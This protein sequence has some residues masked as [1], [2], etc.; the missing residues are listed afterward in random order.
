V[1][2]L[3]QRLQRAL[4]KVGQ[5][6]DDLRA[7]HLPESMPA[8]EAGFPRLGS[9][10]PNDFLKLARVV[11]VDVIPFPPV[12]EYG[13]P[14]FESLAKMSMAGITFRDM[15]FVRPSSSSEGI[16]FHELVH[17]VQWN[18]LGVRE[19]L[20][21]Y[22]LGIVQCGYVQSPLEAIAF[23]LQARFERGV[24]LPSVPER[25]ARHAAE[26]RDAASTVFQTYGL[27]LGA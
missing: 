10:F 5:W 16:H 6:I 24:P 18:T 13:L 8:S 11:S 25:I 27:E 15:Y 1:T 7:K 19:F 22:A 2:D 9:C 26:T 14:E 20:L 21:T 12:S 3:L 17:V 4:P 23:D